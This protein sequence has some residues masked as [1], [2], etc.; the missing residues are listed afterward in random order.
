MQQRLA[1]PGQVT[2]DVAEAAPQPG[3]AHGGLHGGSL[4]RGEC[5]A[6]LA[7]LVGPGRH[8][9]GVGG[10]VDILARAEPRHDRGQALVRQFKRCVPERGQLPRQAPAD[11]DRYEDGQDHREEA[12]PAGQDQPEVGGAGGLAGPD[13]QQAGRLPSG[14]RHAGRDCADRLLPGLRAHRR[15][16]CRGAAADHLVF[17]GHQGC[18]CLRAD[19]AGIEGPVHRVEIGQRLAVHC[20]A[21]ADELGELLPVTGRERARS[22]VADQE[23]ILAQQHLLG[24]PHPHEAQ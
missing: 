5:L 10:C 2:E 3:F 1:A 23:R 13:G 6:D 24:L 22:Q 14:R 21:R 19:V 11:Q 15:R 4:N 7:D 12:E 17:H 20:P 9:R 18:G 8:H 16:D